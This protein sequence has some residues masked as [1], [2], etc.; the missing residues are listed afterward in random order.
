[1]DRVLS[2]ESQDHCLSR[3]QSCTS[4]QRKNIFITRVPNKRRRYP[5]TLNKLGDYLP[6][7]CFYGMLRPPSCV[8]PPPVMLPFAADVLHDDVRHPYRGEDNRDDIVVTHLIK[9]RGDSFLTFCAHSGFI[10][11]IASV[12]IKLTLVFLRGGLYFYI[13]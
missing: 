10:H 2:R 9:L 7:H 4:Y 1:M 13:E 8:Q 12:S 6:D 3:I 5:S 11:S